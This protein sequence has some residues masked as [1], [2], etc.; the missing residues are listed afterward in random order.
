MSLCKDKRVKEL[1]TAV[2]AARMMFGQGT[3]A[4]GQV[5]VQDEF[6]GETHR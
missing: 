4:M 1:E 3:S 2:M 6:A 5:T